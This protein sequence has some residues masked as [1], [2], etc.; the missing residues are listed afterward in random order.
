MEPHLNVMGH[1]SRF[2]SERNGG[3]KAEEL[4]MP[5]ENQR[6]TMV[7]LELHDLSMYHNIPNK[8]TLLPTLFFINYL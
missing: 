5:K 1:P 4:K 3:G 2:V 7:L 8:C 6:I